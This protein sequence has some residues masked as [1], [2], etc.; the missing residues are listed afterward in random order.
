MRS[1]EFV[2]KN[3]CVYSFMHVEN[4]GLVILDVIVYRIYYIVVVFT[5]RNLQR[6]KNENHKNTSHAKA[7]AQ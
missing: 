5:T 6:P 7:K 2:T 1:I 4:S 3:Q